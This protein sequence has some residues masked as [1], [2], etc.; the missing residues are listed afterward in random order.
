MADS[1]S[2]KLRFMGIDIKRDLSKEEGLES[3]VHQPFRLD[4][5]QSDA[6]RIQQTLS[7]ETSSNIKKKNKGRRAK[8]DTKGKSSKKQIKLNNN[9][10]VNEIIEEFPLSMLCEKVVGTSELSKLNVSITD[11]DGKQRVER[12]QIKNSWD[13]LV[14]L[15]ISYILD[16][17]PAKFA[18]NMCKF[19]VANG[20]ILIHSTPVFYPA[21][22]GINQTTYRLGQSNL[23][24]EIRDNPDDLASSIKGAIKFMGISQSDI[25]LTVIPKGMFGINTEYDSIEQVEKTL[26]LVD[27][28]AD[29]KFDIDICKLSIMGNQQ[30]VN[31]IEQAFYIF[32]L[33]GATIYQ[34]AFIKA[35]KA[36]ST[37]VLGIGNGSDIGDKG[38][39]YKVDKLSSIGTKANPQDDRHE[40][41]EDLYVYTTGDKAMTYMFIAQT[42]LNIDI[43][44]EIIEI[45]YK[46]YEL[47]REDKG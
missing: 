22:E 33:W 43:S 18:E 6:D 38:V 42:L 5:L 3:Y 11:R 29:R 23:Y 10:S 44:P 21:S 45:T 30:A 20:S 40:N 8:K 31:S 17:D 4:T 39:G 7:D 12:L 27:I 16:K 2:S 19:E 1:T 47:A 13:G 41:M 35:V 9:I 36:L 37:D 34:D 28:I 26:N 32:I 15:L 46:V 24:I 25:T 14:T